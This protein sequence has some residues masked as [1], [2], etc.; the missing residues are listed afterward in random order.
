M[1][2]LD[3]L[4]DVASARGHGADM[5]KGRVVSA[6]GIAA[7]GLLHKPS[8]IVVNVFLVPVDLVPDVDGSVF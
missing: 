5:V 1:A 7:S 3:V 8:R 4:R 2:N 6:I